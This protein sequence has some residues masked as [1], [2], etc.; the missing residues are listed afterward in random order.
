MSGAF[1]AELGDFFSQYGRWIYI[2]LFAYCFVKSGILPLL[3]G[4]ASA[5]GYL[6][7]WLVM[8]AAFGGS[9]VGDEARFFV[10]RRYRESLPRWPWLTRQIKIATS[11]LEKF[12]AWYIFLYRYP[13]GVRTV[14]ALPMGLTRIPWAKFTTL[15]AA[16]SALWAA[17][18]IG[19]GYFLGEVVAKEAR[20]Y[21]LAASLVLFVIFSAAFA[22]IW[23]QELRRISASSE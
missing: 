17:L 14:G 8:A 21:A 10:A 18:L 9:W 7:V 19:S 23:R 20:N 6:D 3:A 16:S 13:K 15:N 4:Y 22:L 11:L 2:A 1:A 12:G 5:I